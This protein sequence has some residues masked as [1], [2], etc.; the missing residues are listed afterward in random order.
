MAWLNSLRCWWRGHQW[1]A[2]EQMT[3]ADEWMG[4]REEDA[5]HVREMCQCCGESR[6]VFF[7][8]GTLADYERE[9]QAGK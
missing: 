5:I 9:F 8:R 2:T 3:D 1:K 7:G 4:D 6:W